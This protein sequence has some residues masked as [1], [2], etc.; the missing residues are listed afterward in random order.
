M[1]VPALCA[2]GAA[3]AAGDGR[4]AGVGWV[5]A[6]GVLDGAAPAAVGLGST[7]GAAVG[8]GVGR[9]VFV[10]R[11][12][13]R[14]VALGVDEGV[15]SGVLEGASDGGAPVSR[16]RNSAVKVGWSPGFSSPP[17]ATPTGTQLPM[18]SHRRLPGSGAVVMP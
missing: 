9:G 16:R 18:V 11:G 4:L 17:P 2:V 6:V 8:A 14:G 10:G 15:D 13:G 7:V 3:V 12:V 5:E 1:S